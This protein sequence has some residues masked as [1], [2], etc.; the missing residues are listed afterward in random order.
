MII[1]ISVPYEGSHG[2]YLNINSY[3]FIH[4]YLW[5]IDEFLILL[6]Y[7]FIVFVRKN[8]SNY[9]SSKITYVHKSE[10]CKGCKAKKKIFIMYTRCYKINSFIY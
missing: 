10:A 3:T 2:T 7:L 9:V 8:D 5:Y 6:L 1:N 4:S